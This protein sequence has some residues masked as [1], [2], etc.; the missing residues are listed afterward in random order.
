M[1]NF[2]LVIIDGLGVGHQE[3][4]GDFG[5]LGTNTWGHVSTETGVKLPEFQKLGAGNIIPLDS[6]PPVANPSAAFG[7][8][9][10]VSSGKDSTTG[11]WEI[12]GVHLDT[13]FPTYPNGFPDDVIEK[14]L[15]GIGKKQVFANA[16]YSGTDV[17][18]K[19]G[20]QHLETGDPILYTSADSVFQIATHVDVTSVETLYEWCEFARHKICV[21]EHA[22]GRVIAR[23]FTGEPGSFKRLSDQRHDFSRIPPDP[24]LPKYLME[25]GVKTYSVG[26]IIDLFAEIGFT[27]FRRTKSNAEGISQLLSMMSAV[28][29]SFVF[30]NLVDT[31]QN[32]GHRLDTKGYAGS[33]EEF[34]RAIPSI[35]N[36]MNEDDVL[37]L[38]SDHGNDPT[39][40]ITDHTREFTPLLVY[41]KSKAETENLVIRKTFSDVAV[42]ACDYFNVKNPFKGESF[43][44]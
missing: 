20:K 15:K 33:L 44:K 30:V 17:I 3:D 9:R 38:T 11:H 28:E 8:M 7:K 2:Y 21:D 16:P 36:K 31:D 29:N 24:F 19:Y 25:Q 39:G 32:F 13:A 22:V 40:T 1:G 10:E 5:D 43:L 18:E 27:Q 35:L 23:P 37:I 26:K 42:S 12:A 14:F 41:P 34:D 4:A 6:V